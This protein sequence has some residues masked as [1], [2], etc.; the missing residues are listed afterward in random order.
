MSLIK[1]IYYNTCSLLPL[2]LLQK[3]SPATTL[4]PYHHTVSSSFLPHIGHL[5]SYKNENQ[6]IKDLDF[7]L[8]H[9]SP[10][11]VNDFI[12]SVK[13][14][15][16]LPPR[17]FLLSFDDGFRE[18]YD[19]VAPILEKKGV[20][21]IFFINPDFIDN[22]ELFY[23]CKISLLLDA[24]QQNKNNKSF[25]DLFGENLDLQKRSFEDIKINLKKIDHTKI[26]QLNILAE[27]IG[28]S[29]EHFLK[30]QQPFLTSIQLK[31]LQEKG[32]AIGAHSIN[33]PYYHL[34][35]LEEQIKQTIESCNYVTEKTGTRQCCFSFPHSEKEISQEFF[36]ELNKYNIPLIFG[37]QNQKSEFHN[38]V[39]HRFNAERPELRL[40]L[41]VKGLL[42][43]T[44]LRQITGKNVVIRK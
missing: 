18:I 33:H 31:L 5:Y 8:K 26:S 17:S 21:S 2:K 10:I 16:A 43:L 14:N 36:K 39:V 11:A 44:W 12:T 37:I 24:L 3:I 38:N 9:Y 25:L 23:R 27:K 15:H 22:N 34:L 30:D 42:F 41:Q 13:K 40:D 1:N 6:F 32:F 35:G 4:L 28:I 29:F 20:P 7:L 19:I